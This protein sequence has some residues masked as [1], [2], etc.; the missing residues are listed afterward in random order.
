MEYV[1]WDMYSKFPS[2]VESS[3]IVN[4]S[5]RTLVRSPKYFEQRLRRSATLLCFGKGGDRA[6]PSFKLENAV[7]L[8]KGIDQLTAL[9]FQLKFRLKVAL[10]KYEFN[11]E[12]GFSEP[13][14]FPNL[15]Q[16]IKAC[17][18]TLRGHWGRTQR[19]RLLLT[20]AV[21]I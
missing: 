8:S 18:L 5:L 17:G 19:D 16:I 20:V 2:V 13:L 10:L 7:G 11:G 12:L 3:L 15:C 9:N 6:N 21:N 14:S 4:R 1:F